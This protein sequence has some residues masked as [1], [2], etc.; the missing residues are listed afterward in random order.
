MLL[1][2]FT[3]F[4]IFNVLV[5]GES[6]ANFAVPNLL[7]SAIRTPGAFWK[8]KNEIKVCSKAKTEVEKGRRQKKARGQL[9]SRRQKQSVSA[10]YKAASFPDRD[11]FGES[12]SAWRITRHES[13][14]LTSSLV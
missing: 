10:T 5:G 11:Y 4:T 8:E 6:V 1:K 3:S 9:G 14:K 2:F 12:T 13:S 7:V